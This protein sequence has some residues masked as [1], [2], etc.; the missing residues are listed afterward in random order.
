MVD[1]D[2]KTLTIEYENILL[3]SYENRNISNAYFSGDKKS[4]EKKVIALCR[5][6]IEEILHW[7]PQEAKDYLNWS[8]IKKFQLDTLILKFLKFPPG[9]I[10]ETDI[11]YL[12]HLCYPNEIPFNKKNYVLKIYTT[13]LNGDGRFPK[14]FFDGFDGICRACIC[15]RYALSRYYV[16]M[17][18]EELYELFGVSKN[19]NAFL[20]KYKLQSACKNLFDM[21]VD[22]L[23]YSLPEEQK[24]EFLHQYYRFKRDFAEIKKR[25]KKECRY[26]K[27][28]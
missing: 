16:Y 10:P 28:S 1:L 2:I 6:L 19:A 15:L 18:K 26:G 25:K 22:F 24:D 7:T 13:T 14:E 9:I 8:I 12:V 23:H 27:T 17:S 4:K 21:P 11:F 3:Y 5:Y 20:K